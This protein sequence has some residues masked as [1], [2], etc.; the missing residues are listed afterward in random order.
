LPTPSL[1]ATAPPSDRRVLAR[2]A[3]LFGAAFVVALALAVLLNAG[4]RVRATAPSIDV[5]A[6]GLTATRGAGHAGTDAFVVV[7]AGADGVAIVTAAT[8]PF[9]AADYSR[10]SWPVVGDMPPGLEMSLVWRTR[11]R[12]GRTFDA[13]IDVGRQRIQIDLLGHREWAGTID[14]VAL[15]VRGR[16]VAPLALGGMRVRANAWDATLA[17]IVGAWTTPIE[18][19]ART[20]FTPS[21]GERYAIVPILPVVAAAVGLGLGVVALRRRFGRGARPLATV[22][23]MALLG[24]LV[25][26]LRWEALLWSQHADVI[27]RY[28][29]RT[30]DQ[31]AEVGLDGELFAVARRIRDAARPHPARVLVLSD[32]VHL[33]ARIGWFLYPDNVYY[34]GRPGR[35]TVP[36]PADLRAGDQVVLLLYGPIRWDAQQRLLVWRDGRSREAHEILADGPALAVVRVD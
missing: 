14:G 23:A 34:D 28:A 31:K 33:R 24:W 4:P 27:A 10:V 32:N 16:L 5:A 26:D 11:E 2:A 25:L 19:G 7:A 29:G 35:A 9:A 21:A 30:A 18:S 36:A 17:D 3:A 8:P 22:V 15:A 13:P 6:T 20:F 12:P 1:P